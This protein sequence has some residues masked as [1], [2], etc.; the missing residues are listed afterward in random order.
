MYMSL[1]IIQTS[2]AFW[3]KSI[4]MFH[5]KKNTHQTSVKEKISE[6][7]YLYG[8]TH[9]YTH[10]KSHRHHE[11]SII[12]SEGSVLTWTISPFMFTTLRDRRT[13]LY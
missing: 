7:Q 11:E 12:R 2:F 9:T 5:I 4:R 10:T 1:K 6:N 8:N 13:M 3:F